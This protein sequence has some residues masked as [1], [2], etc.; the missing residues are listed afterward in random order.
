[1]TYHVSLAD[2]AGPLS[3]HEFTDFPAALAFYRSHT[4]RAVVANIFTDNAEHDGEHW[5]DGLTEDERE[6][7]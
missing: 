3:T 6:Q 2:C 4:S 7:L 1:M 5:D